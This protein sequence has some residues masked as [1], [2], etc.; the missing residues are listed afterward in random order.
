MGNDILKPASV[1]LTLSGLIWIKSKKGFLEMRTFTEIVH[2]SVSVGHSVLSV[3]H[4]STRIGWLNDSLKDGDC[5]GSDYLSDFW[6]ICLTF[7][8]V[9][10]VPGY[11]RWDLN[12]TL[13]HLINCLV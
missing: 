12:L 2:Q 6:P 3:E 1:L 8:S 11:A 7:G 10:R 4:C 9:H 13:G 5:C